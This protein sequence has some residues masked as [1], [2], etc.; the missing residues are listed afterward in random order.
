MKI[1]N[2]PTI[3][4]KCLRNP[5]IH[6]TSCDTLSFEFTSVF[7]FHMHT[8]SFPFSTS[9]MLLY[10]HSYAGNHGIA[11]ISYYYFK[12]QHFVCSFAFHFRNSLFDHVII[13]TSTSPSLSIWL[14]V[15]IEYGSQLRS[16]GNRLIQNA[17]SKLARLKITF[18]YS[19]A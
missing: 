17:F 2:V 14:V 5:V 4:R 18:T 1:S 16:I 8:L 11:P 13:S 6:V 10:R 12:Y 9:I 3:H 7:N 19:W 15:I